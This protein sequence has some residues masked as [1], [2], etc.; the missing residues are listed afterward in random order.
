MQAA[1]TELRNNLKVAKRQED[2]AYR[3]E[4]RGVVALERRP[5]LNEWCA[6]QS[7][8]REG[9]F[10][11]CGWLKGDSCEHLDEVNGASTPRPRSTKA[12]TS[13]ADTAARAQPVTAPPPEP[14]A[15]SLPLGAAYRLRAVSRPIED[16]KLGAGSFE[17]DFEPADLDDRPAIAGAGLAQTYLIFGGPG[18]GKTYY[19]QYLLSSLLAH[20][21]RPGCLLLDPKG[22]LTRWLRDELEKLNR[23]EDLFLI[24]AGA[25]ETAFNVLGQDL[26]PKEL[27]RLLSEVVLA[28]A[29]GIDEG[30]AVLVGDLLESA[31]VVI[32]ADDRKQLTTEVL[33]KDILYR[34]GFRYPD[35]QREERYP[36]EIRA[37]RVAQEKWKDLDARIACDRIAEYFSKEATEPRLR[38]FVRQVIERTLG[39]LMLPEWGYL[40]GTAA[41]NSLYADII[42]RGRVVSVAVGQSSPAFQR[43]MSTLIKAL[44]QQ[45]VLAHLSKRGPNAA[46]PFFILACDEYA[47]AIT[48]GQT[49]L[50][51]D[52]RFFSLSREAGCMSLLALQSVATGRSR[53]SADMQDRWEGI[54]GNVTVK[55]FMKVNDVETAQMASDLAGSQHSFVQVISQQQSAQ[56]LSAT[57]SL[58]MVEHPRVPPWYLTNRMPQGHAYVHGTLDGKAMSSSLFVRVPR[59]S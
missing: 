40:S 51:S 12:K 34:R 31:A 47:Q 36:I 17:I 6:A 11:F 28:G 48:E 1:L 54:L 25:S 2:L 50:V 15:W 21:R 45:A 29:P 42:E 44:F 19:F 58:S 56:G 53:F 27:G 35:G 32:A 8:P 18:A 7:K 37:K 26:P 10:H 43:S 49:G 57:D 3:S 30:W 39:D 46:A 13:P 5:M 9:V 59:K 23:S 16:G 24:T 14:K 55:M 20:G 33:L 52:S 41:S 38:R 22:A 4:G